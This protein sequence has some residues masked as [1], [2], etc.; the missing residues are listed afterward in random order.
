MPLAAKSFRRQRTFLRSLRTALNMAATLGVVPYSL[1]GHDVVFG[2]LILVR[3]SSL[4]TMMMFV[5]FQYVNFYF[6]AEENL[7]LFFLGYIH[8]YLDLL[9]RRTSSREAVLIQLCSIHDRLAD[10]IAGIQQLYGL[11]ALFIA[12]SSF[13]FINCNFFFL[14]KKPNKPA[15]LVCFGWIIHSFIL[16]YRISNRC[17]QIKEKVNIHNFS[18]YV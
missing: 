15:A 5:S 3:H 6:F 17:K 11:T 13:C 16:I 10:V 9:V 14:M 4:S 1:R 8:H 18:I 7:I 2:H 12:I